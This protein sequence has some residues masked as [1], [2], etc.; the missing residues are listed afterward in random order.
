M[1]KSSGRKLHVTSAPQCG[2]V[3][4][5][6]LSES[7]GEGS[8]QQRQAGSWPL[9]APFGDKGPSV[10]HRVYLWAGFP[11]PERRFGSC[12]CHNRMALGGKRFRKGGGREKAGRGDGLIRPFIRPG[13]PGICGHLFQPLSFHSLLS[14]G[15]CRCSQNQFLPSG[16]LETFSRRRGASAQNKHP[17][18]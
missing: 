5:L 10:D 6:M 13:S 18:W 4:P 2:F 1:E 11:K 9:S 3:T 14:L 16:A 8:G 15:S 7:L 12:G 17:S